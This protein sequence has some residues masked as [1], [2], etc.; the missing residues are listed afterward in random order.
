LTTVDRA[1]RAMTKALTEKIY[2]RQ[3]SPF[4]T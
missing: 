2:L 1:V 3:V 4:D